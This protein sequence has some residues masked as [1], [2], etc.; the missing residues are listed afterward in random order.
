MNL[1]SKLFGGRREENHGVRLMKILKAREAKIGDIDRAWNEIRQEFTVQFG[2]VSFCP[3]KSEIIKKKVTAPIEQLISRHHGVGKG[4]ISADDKGIAFGFFAL[5]ADDDE[6]EAIESEIDQI[7]SDAGATFKK[8]RPE[9][10]TGCKRVVRN[11]TWIPVQNGSV[12]GCL[13]C[14]TPQPK[15]SFDHENAA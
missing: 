2:Y 13:H 8:L 14:K 12:L 1:F 15:L 6:V 3:E 7:L 4:S 9:R 11:W 5:C 10:C